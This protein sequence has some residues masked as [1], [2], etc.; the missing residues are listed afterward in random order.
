M[1]I[2]KNHLNSSMMSM[3]NFLINSFVM[4]HISF[5]LFSKKIITQSSTKK[6]I[7]ISQQITMHDSWKFS[8]NSNLCK[9]LINFRC[10]KRNDYFKSYN[11]LFNHKIFF[12]FSYSKNIRIKIISF[13]KTCT[14]TFTT[15][16][17]R[18]FKLNLTMSVNRIHKT[19]IV[20]IIV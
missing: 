7:M 5:H 12:C 18:I 3:M 20:K 9:T 14:K 2:F 13:K 11:I 16:N 6:K 1:C 17:C 8:V 15:S 4:I 19:M 10:H